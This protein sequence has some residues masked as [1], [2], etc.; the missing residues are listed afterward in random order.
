MGRPRKARTG[1]KKADI[2][3]FLEE[4]ER[5]AGFYVVV[6]AGRPALDQFTPSFDCSLFIN[7]T[8]LRGY[9]AYLEGNCGRKPRAFRSVD[10]I[11]KKLRELGYSVTVTVYNGTTRVD[12]R[13]REVQRGAGRVPSARSPRRKAKGESKLAGPVSSTTL[14]SALAIAKL[15]KE[16]PTAVISAPAQRPPWRRQPGTPR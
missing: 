9:Y 5:I 16:K 2:R 12:L 3:I 6:R 1:F 7:I 8:G 11:L 4:G 15:V 13:L 14:S 10:R